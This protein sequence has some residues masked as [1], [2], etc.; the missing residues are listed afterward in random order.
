MHELKFAHKTKLLHHAVYIPFH[1]LEFY[2]ILFY[3]FV[4]LSWLSID[5]NSL[6]SKRL[7]IKY[8]LFL[9]LDNGC[10][11]IAHSEAA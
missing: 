7:E 1:C 2:F 9:H 10:V 8:V 6:W 5:E 4:P 11:I 3:I